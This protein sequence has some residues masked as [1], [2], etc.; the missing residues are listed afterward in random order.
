MKIVLGNQERFTFKFLS[1]QNFL[2]SD[3][4]FDQFRVRRLL[5]DTVFSFTSEHLKVL[6]LGFLPVGM[7]HAPRVLINQPESDMSRVTM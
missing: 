1:A 3:N 5:S 2:I 4:C 6:W 7:L